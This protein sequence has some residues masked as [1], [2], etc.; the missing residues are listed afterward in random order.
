MVDGGA[1]DEPAIALPTDDERVAD[2]ARRVA[3]DGE[4]M[5]HEWPLVT[6]SFIPLLAVL[7]ASLAG[8][9]VQDAS[10]A[11]MWTG[12]GALILWGELAGRHS[13]SGTWG[14]IG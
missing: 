8:A 12:V 14:A 13:G 2:E 3:V 6:A 7:L 9:S 4:T 1:P 10:L 5:G 11:G